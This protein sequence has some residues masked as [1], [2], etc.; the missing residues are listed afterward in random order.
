M[1]KL[2]GISQI[3]AGVLAMA[4]VGALAAPAM[5]SQDDYD[6]AFV[7][8]E[9]A[10]AAD[11]G[12][13]VEALSFDVRNIRSRARTTKVTYRVSRTDGTALANDSIECKVSKR[14]GEVTLEVL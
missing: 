10:I 8:C 1:N 12:V 13:A 7:A 6:A 3:G 5:S 4:A 14:S 9:A 2:L 11:A